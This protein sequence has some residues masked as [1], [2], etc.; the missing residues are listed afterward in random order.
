MC[1]GL[2]WSVF[3]G[4]GLGAFKS[5][6]NRFLFFFFVSSSLLSLSVCILFFLGTFGGVGGFGNFPG[7]GIAT[8]EWFMWATLSN[9]KED[10]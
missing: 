6:I 4:E 7:G 3:D 10:S 1:N 9:R 2:D 8:A 5:V